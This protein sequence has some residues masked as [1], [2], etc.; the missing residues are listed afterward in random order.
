MHIAAWHGSAPVL[1]LEPSGW[2]CCRQP[3]AVQVSRVQG[4]PSSHRGAVAVHSPPLQAPG[5]VQLPEPAVQVAASAIATT[6]QR[7]STHT[8]ARQLGKVPRIAAHVWSLLQ[9][10]LTSGAASPIAS[11]LLAVPSWV[12][13]LVPAAG[14][15]QMPAKQR[16]LGQSLSCTHA[17]VGTAGVEQPTASQPAGPAQAH[18]NIH[19]GTRK[20]AHR[21]AKPGRD[22]KPTGMG[23]GLNGKAIPNCAGQGANPTL[24]RAGRVASNRGFRPR[25]GCRFSLSIQ[26]G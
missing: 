10:A 21:L 25:R 5:A 13:S 1:Q 17:A 2:F 9:L 15:V 7:P 26:P 11:L 22:R 16:P 19:T 12:A 3:S 14:S 23:Q 20:N 8:A 18:T 6:E 4:L 24:Y